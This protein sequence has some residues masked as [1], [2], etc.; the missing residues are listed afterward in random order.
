[1]CP[2]FC[3]H[4]RL[5]G[6]IKNAPRHLGVFARNGGIRRWWAEMVGFSTWWDKMVGCPFTP[7]SYAKKIKRR[8]ICFLTDLSPLFQ[9]PFII[10][11]RTI[12]CKGEADMNN[13]IIKLLNLED[14]CIITSIE[15][16]D[17]MTKTIS[18]AK[19]HSE[20]FCPLC[21]YRMHSKGVRIRRAKHQMLLD[22]YQLH[23]KLY[24]R[25]Y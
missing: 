10:E 13:D 19:N 20:K 23:L 8:F 25:R 22:S 14:D 11:L 4:P 7:P 1:M 12:F 3:P 5:D 18:L 2:G 6:Y 21:N 24:C 16:S 15:T 17:N 9:F